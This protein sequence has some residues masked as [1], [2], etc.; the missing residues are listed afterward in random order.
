LENKVKASNTPIFLYNLSPLYLHFY[1]R[2]RYVWITLSDLASQARK[3]QGQDQQAFQRLYDQSHIYVIARIFA[4]IEQPE[5]IQDIEQEVWLAAF[6]ALP[7]LQSLETFLAWIER[8]A[9]C[10]AWRWAQQQKTQAILWMP[11]WLMP[12]RG[13]MIP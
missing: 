12:W 4:I 2:R 7:T 13:R 11:G 10:Y 1:T 9:T 8:I 6:L 5:A 3:T